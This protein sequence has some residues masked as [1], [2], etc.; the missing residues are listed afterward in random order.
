MSSELS[1]EQLPV[2]VEE[3]LPD[4]S[5]L[6]EDGCGDGE[7]ERALLAGDDSHQGSLGAQQD[8]QV[9]AQPQLRRGKPV[10]VVEGLGEDQHT[11]KI[12]AVSQHLLSRGD[13]W[14]ARRAV[15]SAGA[16]P[17]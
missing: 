9:A 14:S 6:A 3:P 13:A 8:L 17:A 12:S 10:L 4:G 11:I 1:A 5:V 7:T 15:W 16:Q 2:L